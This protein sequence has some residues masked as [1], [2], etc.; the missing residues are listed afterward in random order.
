MYAGIKLSFEDNSICKNLFLRICFCWESRLSY[1][2]MDQKL[3]LGGTI[4]YEDT[5]FEL[6]FCP[7]KVFKLHATL[8]DAAGAI[9]THSDNGPGYCN[10]IGWGPNSCWLGHETG[11]LSCHYVKLFLPSNFNSVDFWS[12]MSCFVL[13]IEPTD[14]NVVNVFGKFI[15]CKVQAYSFRD[16]K[17][18]KPTKQSFWCTPNMHG[19]VWNS[20]LWNYTELANFIPTAVKGEYFA[21]GTEKCKILGNLLDKE[22]ENL[23]DHDCPK[24]SRSRSRRNVDLL[25]LSIQIPDHILLCRAQGKNV[26]QLDIAAFNVVTFLMLNVLLLSTNLYL[27]KWI[28]PFFEFHYWEIERRRQMTDQE[29]AFNPG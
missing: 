7:F 13:D 29:D 9:R 14:K 20:G 16:L 24:S 12:R 4:G 2:E 19:F 8:N 26:L 21:K 11:L 6:L 15:D 5:Y 18:I 23:E 22:L 3:E 28:I 25:E 17:K 27:L 10:K 1:S